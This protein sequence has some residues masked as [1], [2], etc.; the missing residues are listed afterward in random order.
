MESIT[1]KY[2]CGSNEKK[3]MVAEAVETKSMGAEAEAVSKL[4]SGSGS[5]WLL[6]SGSGSGGFLK[7]RS[8]SGSG[9]KFTTS[10]HC[11]KDPVVQ[12]IWQFMTNLNKTP[13]I[14]ATVSRQKTDKKNVFFFAGIDSFKIF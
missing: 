14:F 12:F 4:G 3:S 9:N 1:D 13:F 2:P 5:S 6:I 7:A 8:E 11:L 10:R